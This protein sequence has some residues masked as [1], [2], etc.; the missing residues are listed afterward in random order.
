MARNDIIVKLRLAGEQFDRDFKVKFEELS[1]AAERA[2]ADAGTRAGSNFGRNFAVAAGT[3]GAAIGLAIN[4]AAALGDEIA[5]TSRQFDI[6]VESLQVWRQAAA[7]AGLTSSEFTSV[8]GTLAD[9]IGEANAGNAKAQQSF[10]NLGIGF[11]TASGEARATDAVLL[12]LAKRISEIEDPSERVR[13]GTDLLGR[14]FKDLHPLLLQG[15][16]GFNQAAEDLRTFGAV[17]SEKEIQELEKTNAKIEQMKTV[18]S[19]SVARVVA[20][21][22][23][24]IIG[25]ANS[26][27]TLT[28]AMIKYA[29]EYPRFSGALA[30]AGIGYRVG[31]PI[32][33]AV[34]AL[35]G[36][37]VGQ[38]VARQQ[39]DANMDVEFRLARLREAQRR[40]EATTRGK[41]PRDNDRIARD[42]QE[43]LL[44]QTKLFRD[45][46][47]ARNGGGA[48]SVLAETIE[49]PRLT[50]GGGGARRGGGPRRSAGPS[51]AE[52]EAE[53]QAK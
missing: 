2:S 53:R 22:A 25:L 9:R 36:L 28:G 26:I 20:E 35:G 10:V 48:G 12:D 46:M 7:N 5:S 50:A 1:A 16:D 15:A 30:G 39:A 51:A 29:N 38:G 31:G 42:A 49:A 8:L 41:V 4:K 37:A 40:V 14:Q 34:G 23:D 33:A 43:E 13:L 17:L 45:A 21:N 44:R 18:L 47:R 27:A 32:G 19:I 52:R 11:K 24:A 6:G 3:A